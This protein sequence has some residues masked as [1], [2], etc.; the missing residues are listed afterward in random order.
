VRFEKWQALGN[1]WSY[2]GFADGPSSGF[3][4][5]SYVVH[6][7]IPKAT[8][9]QIRRLHESSESSPVADS[10]APAIPLQLRVE[11]GGGPRNE[12]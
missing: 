8:P 3:D 7:T 9:E 10:L 12:P 5:I 4:A 2:L 1:V 11:T 6:V